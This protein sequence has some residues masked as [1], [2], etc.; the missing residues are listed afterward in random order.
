MVILRKNDITLNCSLWLNVIPCS[1]Q[2][3][4]CTS[5]IRLNINTAEEENFNTEV[6]NLFSFYHYPFVYDPEI[7]ENNFIFTYPACLLH[8]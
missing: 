8:T 4:S 5:K 3:L 1:N 2:V 7:N 6:I